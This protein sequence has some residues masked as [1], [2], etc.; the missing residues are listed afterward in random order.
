MSSGQMQ[1]FYHPGLINSKELQL[2][3]W[4]VGQTFLRGS[5]I[6]TYSRSVKPQCISIN[7]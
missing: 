3:R 7:H 2:T 1:I 4:Y 5:A 6:V